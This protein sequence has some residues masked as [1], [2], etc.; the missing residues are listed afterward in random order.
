MASVC[1]RPAASFG[2]G[3]G[4]PG[5]VPAVRCTNS[6]RFSI[7]IIRKACERS[8]NTSTSRQQ[9]SR[10]AALGLPSWDRMASKVRSMADSSRRHIS[11]IAFNAVGSRTSSFE[12]AMERTSLPIPEDFWSPDMAAIYN[13]WNRGKTIFHVCELVTFALI[14]IQR[15]AVCNK[16]L[17]S[18]IHKFAA[19]NKFLHLR[20]FRKSGNWR[21]CYFR[22]QSFM[23]FSD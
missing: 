10:I 11:L 23:W 21:I 2:G 15:W 22:A 17:K 12:V 14:I 5:S 20:N 8:N 7:A 18:Q 4:R 1:K 16:F 19:F 6:S 13:I 9:L 3:S